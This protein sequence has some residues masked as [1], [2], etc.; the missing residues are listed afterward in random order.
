MIDVG[1]A[2]HAYL[3]AQSIM[4]QLWVDVYQIE[5]GFERVW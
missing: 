2:M 3:Q 5:I 4:N 1:K